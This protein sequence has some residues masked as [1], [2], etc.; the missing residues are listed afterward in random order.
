MKGIKNI[1]DFIV[2]NWTYITLLISLLYLAY[3]KIKEFRKLSDEQKV[4]AAITIIR[5]IIRKNV[6]TAEIQWEDFAK[7]GS[8]KRAQVISEVYETFPFLKDIYDQKTLIEEMDNIID[9]ALVD[10]RK[11]VSNKGTSDENIILE[12]DNL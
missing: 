10:V 4:E 1:I 3:H 5:E 7:T 12:D 6:M 11:I 9:E 2:N 8:I